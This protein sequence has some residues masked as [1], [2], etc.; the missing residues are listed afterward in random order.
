MIG[1]SCCARINRAVST[2]SS[3]PWSLM[4]I[5]RR[6]GSR[7]AATAIALSPVAA[8]AGTSYPSA[9]R[10]FCRSRAITFSSSTTSMRVGFIPHPHSNGG[11][12]PILNQI[13]WQNSPLCARGVLRFSYIRGLCG[14]AWKVESAPDIV[15]RCSSVFVHAAPRGP[16]KN[17]P[18]EF[19]GGFS[20]CWLS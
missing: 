17:P 13:V 11:T 1:T 18:T 6:S 3:F 15:R 7:S 16:T 9:P 19:A 5:S 12:F 8:T 4:S 2:P 20:G 14:L 10:R